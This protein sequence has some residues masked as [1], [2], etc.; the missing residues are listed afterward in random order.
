MTKKEPGA[1]PGAAT[2]SLALLVGM[3]AAHGQDAN[4]NTVRVS[5]A[6]KLAPLL[7]TWT[8]TGK[9]YPKSGGPAVAIASVSVC[10]W[11]ASRNFLIADQTNPGPN[12]PSKD[13][14]VFGYDRALKT[15]TLHGMDAEGGPPFTGSLHIAGRTWVYTGSFTRDGKTVLTRTL[16]VFTSPSAITFTVQQSPDNGAHWITTAAGTETRTKPP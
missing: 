4:K 8:L 7:G 1:A 9:R 16:N 6:Q 2:F 13:V 11:S 12:G 14:V 3:G 15:F 10:R 5:E